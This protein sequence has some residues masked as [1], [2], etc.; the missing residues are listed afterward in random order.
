MSSILIH[1]WKVHKS[2][3]EYYLT[4]IHW[5]YLK[6]IL[7]YYDDIC[8]LASIS[9]MKDNSDQLMEIGY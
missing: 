8:L 7:K 2:G 5:I 3:D 9:I 4:Y 6:E 1:G